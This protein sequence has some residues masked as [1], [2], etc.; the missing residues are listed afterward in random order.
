M[1][2]NFFCCCHFEDGRIGPSEMT[3]W[4]PATPSRTVCSRPVAF[5]A[6]DVRF[7]RWPESRGA[8]RWPPSSRGHGSAVGRVGPPVRSTGQVLRD[9]PSPDGAES[10]G[11]S[12]GGR[13]GGVT[14]FC[15]DGSRR[16][17]AS[18]RRGRRRREGLA[19]THRRLSQALCRAE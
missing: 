1:Y 19:S 13:V 17:E 18:K 15:S 5:G 14:C 6:T 3:V 11:D 4:S 12:R 7:S 2:K 10:V 16:K 8:S 9:V